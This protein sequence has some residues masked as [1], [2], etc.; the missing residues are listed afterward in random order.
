VAQRFSAA[1]RLMFPLS[2]LAAEVT[3]S[4]YSAA[5]RARGP[6]GFER[7][8]KY[9]PSQYRYRKSVSQSQIRG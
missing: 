3:G 9:G 8:E 7:R 5:S 6:C 2:A 1:I 4:T